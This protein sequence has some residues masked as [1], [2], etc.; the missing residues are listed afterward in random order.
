MPVGLKVSA[1]AKYVRTSARKARLVCD[2]IRGKDVVEA[3]AILAFATRDAAKP[4]LKLLESAVANAEH[5]H[6]LVGEDLKIFAVHADEG[7]TL[8][9]YRPRAMGRATRIRKRTSHLT[10]TLTPKES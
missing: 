8:K 3:R 10:I 4:W 7:P 1:Q 6:E 2:H 9:R 5:N